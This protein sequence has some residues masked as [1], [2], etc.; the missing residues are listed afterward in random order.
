[1]SYKLNVFNN[2]TP[3]IFQIS[4]SVFGDTVQQNKKSRSSCCAEKRYHAHGI[5]N[6]FNMVYEVKS[7]VKI[8]LTLQRV[9]MW[10]CG[11]ITSSVF[12]EDCATICRRP[13]KQT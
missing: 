5:V 8:S 13:D 9:N 6:G 1:M 12:S 11:D 2:K 10:T 3:N 4:F 7:K